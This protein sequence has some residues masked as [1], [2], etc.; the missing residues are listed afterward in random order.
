MTRKSKLQD[1][2]PIF[3]ETGAELAVPETRLPAE[4]PML[5]L[6]NSQP[7]IDNI[8]LTQGTS[9]QGTPGT[10][11]NV[12]TGEESSELALIPFMIQPTRALFSGSFVR[13][14]G[15]ECSSNDGV[16]AVAVLPSGEMPK[17]PGREC[18]ACEHNFMP[19]EPREGLEPC[20][21]GYTCLFYD[22]AGQGVVK[23][24]FAGTGLRIVE[25]LLAKPHIFQ[26]Q[27][28]RLIAVRQTSERGSWWQA[29]GTAIGEITPEQQ[30][31]IVALGGR[32]LPPDTPKEAA[33]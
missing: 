23:M 19:W 13:D 30:A 32:F 5:S 24:R 2:Q 10:F 31:D 20:K 29:V 11:L 25:R 4:N 1:D 17:Y 33:A 16:T 6:H 22:V 18:L 26:R 7:P 12:E 27:V 3:D 8:K 28:V 14:R 21:A 9:A 15:P